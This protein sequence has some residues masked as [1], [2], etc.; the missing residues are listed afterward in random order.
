[1]FKQENEEGRRIKKKE[2]KKVLFAFT[3]LCGNRWWKYY[4]INKERESDGGYN[5]EKRKNEEQFYLHLS[6]ILMLGMLGMLGIVD[7][8]FA[9]Y[10]FCRYLWTVRHV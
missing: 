2:W 8:G 5:E 7:D 4:K 9:R 1:M 3:T 6:T 10:K